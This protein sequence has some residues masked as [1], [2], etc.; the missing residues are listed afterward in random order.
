[1][2]GS[3]QRVLPG[4]TS[5]YGHTISTPATHPQLPTDRRQQQNQNKNQAE[6]STTAARRVRVLAPQPVPLPPQVAR[7]P[8]EQV[9]LIFNMYRTMNLK[10]PQVCNQSQL[11]QWELGLPIPLEYLNPPAALPLD[12]E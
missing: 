3:S 9:D 8:Q 6:S 11:H 1:M 12:D 5:L 7:L 2:E 10:M 4:R